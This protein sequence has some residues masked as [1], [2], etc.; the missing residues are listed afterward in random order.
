MQRNVSKILFIIIF[1]ADDIYA[2]G[3]NHLQQSTST[4]ISHNL[5]MPIFSPNY[6]HGTLRLVNDKIFKTISSR[7]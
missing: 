5:A 7:V 2:Q 6:T 4:P 1:I 3:Y